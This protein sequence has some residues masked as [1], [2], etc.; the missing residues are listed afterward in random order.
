MERN[1]LGLTIKHIKRMAFHLAVRKNIPR[2]FFTEK[3]KN[4][5]KW[6][7]IFF[8]KA[9]NTVAVT[10]RSNTGIAGSNPTR[11]IDVCVRLFCVCVVL[12]VGS[13]FATG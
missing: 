12:C 11:G 10:A 4:V 2:S 5:Q 8:G 13:G 3:G 7:G 9:F 1:F 6:L